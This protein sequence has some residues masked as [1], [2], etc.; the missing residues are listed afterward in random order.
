[1]AIAGKKEII[2]K[3]ESMTNGVTLAFR[4][5]TVFG[6]GLALVELNPA[7]PQKKQKK[8]LMRWGKELEDTRKQAPL[9]ST[10]KA[11]SIA[12]WISDRSGEWVS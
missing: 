9:L 7:Y 2:Q 12:G 6:A 5:G 4:L 8:Y 3:M 11:K 10:D 1:M